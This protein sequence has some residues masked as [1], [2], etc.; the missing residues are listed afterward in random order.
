MAFLDLKFPNLLNLLLALNPFLSLLLALNPLLSLLLAL[1]LPLNLLLALNPLNLLLVLNLPSPLNPNLARRLARRDR[2]LP[3]K[4]TLRQV[5]I[6]PASPQVN[7]RPV[8]E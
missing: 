7:L 1:N 5:E 8:Q 2:L 6:I 3:T 4:V